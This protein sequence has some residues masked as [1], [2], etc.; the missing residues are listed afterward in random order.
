ME[1]LFKPIFYYVFIFVFFVILIRII[2]ED[3]GLVYDAFF[4]AVIK[5]CFAFFSRL[6]VINA[7]KIVYSNVKEKVVIN[8]SVCFCLDRDL[9][10]F[11]KMILALKAWFCSKI[12]VVQLN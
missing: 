7:R 5:I 4:L 10:F 1:F 3:L 6:F 9:V 8:Y 2:F 11:W 12:S